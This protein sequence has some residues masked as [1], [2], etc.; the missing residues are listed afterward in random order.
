MFNIC[1]YNRSFTG[2]FNS[3][4]RLLLVRELYLVESNQEGPL[5]AGRHPPQEIIEIY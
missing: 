5:F 3:N 1:G 4:Q 2:R